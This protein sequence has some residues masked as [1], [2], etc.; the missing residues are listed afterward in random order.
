MYNAVSKLAV[1]AVLLKLG[2]NGSQLPVYYV[3]K[4]MLSADQN[5]TMLENMSLALQMA[6]KKLRPY[7]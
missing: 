4:A 2:L 7:F 6:S 3:G 5:Y 1:N